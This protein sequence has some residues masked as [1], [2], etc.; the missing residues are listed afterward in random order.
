[1]R[2]C[3]LTYEHMRELFLAEYLHSTTILSSRPIHNHM[4]VTMTGLKAGYV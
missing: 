3:N 2:S 1:M 4:D